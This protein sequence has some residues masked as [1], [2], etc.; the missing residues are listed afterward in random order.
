MPWLRPLVAL[1]ALLLAF[2]A[3]AE[4]SRTVV[5]KTAIDG[6]TLALA[7]GATLRLVG[8]TAPKAASSGAPGLRALA[9]AAREA[10]DALAAGRPLELVYAG[11]PRDRHGRLLAHARDRQGRWL[12]GEL[13]AGGHA[14]V[15]TTSDNS[16]HAGDMLH[17]EREARVRGLGLWADPRFRVLTTDETPR[18]LDSFQLVEGT[19]VSVADLRGR[20]YINFGPDWRSDF[21]IALD[22]RTL[23]TLARDRPDALTGRR[24][25]VRGWLKSFNGPMIE[26]THS[27]QIELLEP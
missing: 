10:L 27:E 11:N 15:M 3:G 13:L 23:R 22:R 6:D 24:V 12:Q 17:L 1:L 8:I 9:R 20:A 25:R 5:A 2:Q 7:D 21:T 26:A 4:P 19:V 18:H 16:A 14:R